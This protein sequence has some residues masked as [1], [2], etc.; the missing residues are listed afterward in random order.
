MSQ[1]TKVI[2]PRSLIIWLLIV[3]AVVMAVGLAGGGLLLYPRYQLQQ[4]VKQHYQAGVA[5]QAVGDWEAAEA[6]YRQV[7]ILDADYKDAQARLADV[8]ARLGEKEATATAVAMAQAERARAEAQATAV[9]A[10][11]ATTE[12]RINAQATAAAAP[13]ATAEALETHYQRALGYMNMERWA[14]AEAELEQV[15]DM[16]P[17]YK[18]IQV[19]LAE[20]EAE[21]A[22]LTPTATPTPVA[23]A[24]PAFLFSDNFDDDDAQGWTVIGSQAKVVGGQ[25]VAIGDPIVVTLAGSEAWR[26]YSF[27]AKIKVISGRGDF[28]LLAR[29]SE[30]CR[31]YLLQFDQ[32]TPDRQL[33]LVR[34]DGGNCA[35]E[36]SYPYSILAFMP[37]QVELGQWYDFRV[38]VQGT[39]ITGYVNGERLI[40]AEDAFYSQ[41]KIGLRSHTTQMF[42][43]DIEVVP[44]PRP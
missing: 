2:G 20:V 25:Y 35:D 39:T 6:E 14:E 44:L 28:A 8:K 22:K 29:A 1:R 11:T 41:G 36:K 3:I 43:E 21:L 26:D 7:V 27:R 16:D 31:L 12:A 32:S 37:Y 15:F 17:N 18:D 23:T 19:K 24:T 33:R 9:V 40:S 38:D 30:D 5:F 4:Q 34:F 42:F 13:T 10:A